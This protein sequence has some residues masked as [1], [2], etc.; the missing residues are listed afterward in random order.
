MRFSRHSGTCDARA[1]QQQRCSLSCMRPICSHTG[2]TAHLKQTAT[3]KSGLP[4][5]CCI[6]MAVVTEEQSEEWEEGMPPL[7]KKAPRSHTCWSR[8]GEQKI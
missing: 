1:A 2:S 6:A 8:A 5:P 4:S 3:E 7:S